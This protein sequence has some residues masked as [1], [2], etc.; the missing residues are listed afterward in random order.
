MRPEDLAACRA[1]LVVGSKSFATAARI[2][3]R[4]VRAP[5]TA[6]YA[7]CRVADDA[8]DT[9]AD[10]KASVRR[11]RERLDAI[12]INKPINHPADRAFAAVVAEYEMPKELPGALI[13]GFEWDAEERRYDTLDALHAYC[14][15]VA[16]TVGAMMA[17][18][19]GVRDGPRLARA[20]DL[21]VA[22]QLTNIARDIGEDARNGRIY[23]PLDWMREAG[24]DPEAWQRNPSYSPALREI[25][26]R[27][28]ANA[29]MLYARSEAGIAALPSD[30][31]SSIRAAGRI[32]AEIGR[33]VR[34]EGFDPVTKRA[35]V[36]KSRKLMLL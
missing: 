16:G 34:A 32:Y 25:T 7:F 9:E 8:V 30:C 26:H 35:I 10:P 13:E 21:G 17:L 33:M 27:M 4:R 22:M 15:R 12:Y 29:D 11:L 3:P 23:L 1:A 36:P 14:A 5:A 2:L 18:L 31:R 24:I 20:C 28:L 19:M 6:L